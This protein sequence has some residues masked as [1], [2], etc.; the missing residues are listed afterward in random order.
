MASTLSQYATT[1]RVANDE[2]SLLLSLDAW[3]DV[4]ADEF[5]AGA[6][7]HPLRP[8]YQK[9]FRDAVRQEKSFIER[10]RRSDG[11]LLVT[12]LNIKTR[13]D[14]LA[15]QHLNAREPALI[16]GMVLGPPKL[17]HHDEYTTPGVACTA[18]L[19][20]RTGALAG[21]WAGITTYSGNHA[22]AVSYLT[23][24]GSSKLALRKPIP[25][26]NWTMISQAKHGLSALA[27]LGG[28]RH[29]E[30]GWFAYHYDDFVRAVGA[31][32]GILTLPLVAGAS[33]FEQTRATPRIE[34]LMSMPPC[35][36]DDDQPQTGCANYFSHLRAAVGN[37]IP[38]VLYCYRPFEADQAKKQVVTIDAGGRRIDHRNVWSRG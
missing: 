6:P 7:L 20:D 35:S 33:L 12:T 5:L 19:I 14:R 13:F 34:F 32:D 2:E 3:V 36:R 22:S 30:D 26:T 8:V 28:A 21:T 11:T 31:L 1:A 10:M 15:N 17:A 23:G 18:A 27:C 38:I 29:A 9:G 16:D 4:A 25:Q 37:R 24:G